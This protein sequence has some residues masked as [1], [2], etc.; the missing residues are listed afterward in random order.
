MEGRARVGEG[1][2]AG[3]KS[4]EWQVVKRVER[5]ERCRQYGGGK[6]KRSD[7]CIKVRGEVASW[8]G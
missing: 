8:Q 5:V 1:N 2:L 6:L 4:V 3:Q 7:I